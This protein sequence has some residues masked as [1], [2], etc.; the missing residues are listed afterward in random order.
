MLA[1]Q[2][3]MIGMAIL[4][5]TFIFCAGAKTE[6]NSILPEAEHGVNAR[7]AAGGEEAGG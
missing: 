6:L 1:I 4:G 2:G 7:G 3:H 5:R